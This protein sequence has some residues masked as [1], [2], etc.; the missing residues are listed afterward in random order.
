MK[1]GV[2]EPTEFKSEN[3]FS[4]GLQASLRSATI[5]ALVQGGF[6]GKFAVGNEVSI[7]EVV[8][9]KLKSAREQIRVNIE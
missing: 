7:M 8:P 6:A 1:I 5:D 9:V 4:K 2:L 3:R